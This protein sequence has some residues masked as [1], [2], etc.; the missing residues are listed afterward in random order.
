MIEIKNI[1]KSKTKIE[2]VDE[3]LELSIE[4]QDYLKS[5]KWCEK[6]INGWL[7][8]EWGYM[9]SIF[10]FEIKPSIGSEADNFVWVIVGDLPPAYIDI[11]SASNEIEALKIYVYLME[12][13]I[14][15][16]KQGKSIED[17]FPVNVEPSNEFADMLL[18]RINIIKED[19]LP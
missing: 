13:W 14:N 10:Y 6:I 4:A 9:L 5:F 7:V 16:I 8:K 18:S 2:F 12:E 19:F 17:C 1:K 3:V 11:Q 15:N